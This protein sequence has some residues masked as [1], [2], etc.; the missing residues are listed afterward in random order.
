MVSWKHQW[1]VRRAE[2]TF[3]PIRRSD[4]LTLPVRHL[5][6]RKRYCFS[7]HGGVQSNCTN[8]SR[9]QRTS[10]QIKSSAFKIFLPDF[11]K[12]GKLSILFPDPQS[13]VNYFTT[14]KIKWKLIFST[15]TI[16]SI[17]LA[18]F[19]RQSTVKL[20]KKVDGIFWTSFRINHDSPRP[21]SVREWD[22]KNRKR[23][24]K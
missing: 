19:V 4:R 18:F 21:V 17:S 20:K 9:P 2:S 3:E 16:V 22:R 7:V 6:S 12:E 14:T 23:E 1:P 5:R 10:R 11:K 13:F 24:A 15:T 8:P